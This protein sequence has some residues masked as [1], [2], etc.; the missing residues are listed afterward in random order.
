MQPFPVKVMI[1]HKQL[2]NLEYYKYVGS[3]ITNNIIC[4]GE[5]KSRFVM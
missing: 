3:M 4:T 1:D 2:D 5:I